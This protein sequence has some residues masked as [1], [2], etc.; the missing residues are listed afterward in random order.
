[1]THVIK[2]EIETGSQ[3]HFTMEPQSCVCIPTEDGIDVYPASQWIDLAQTSIASCLGVPN[4]RYDR[5]L[6]NWAAMKAWV[7]FGLFPDE[8]IQ[9]DQ[10]I[11]ALVVV[12]R[13]FFHITKKMNLS[14]VRIRLIWYINGPVISR[15]T[16]P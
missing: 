1:M 14:K 13:L 10:S 3:Y 11:G 8:L 16:Q 12:L 4:N 5:K 7:G 15:T 2:G 9:L 6:A